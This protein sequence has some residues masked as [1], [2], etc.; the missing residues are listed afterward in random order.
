MEGRLAADNSARNPQ[1]TATT[2]NAL[3]IGVFLV[4]LV[5]VSGTSVKDFAVGEINKL[6][7]ADYLVVSEG[8]TIDPRLVKDLKGIDGVDRVVPFRTEVVSQDRTRASVSTGD[9]AQLRDIADIDVEQG[10]IDA[11]GPG[12]IAVIDT[13]TSRT[14]RLGAT[15]EV[16]TNDGR[17]A[18]L[19]VVALLK[20][21]IDANVVGSIV[22]RTTF[23]RLLGDVAPTVAFLDLADGAQTS[24]RHAIERRV[25]LRPD[26]TLQEGNAAGRLIG[27]IFD[28]MINAVVG[29]LLM[30]VVIA[31][32]GII[33][34]LS[35]SI[36]ERRRELGLL[37]VIGMTDD[38]VRR[39]VSLES[40]LI[41]G[42]GTVTGMLAGLWISI[43]LIL[44]INRLTDASIAVS[45][46]YLE[47]LGVLLA[48]VVLGVLAALIPARRSTRLEVLDA[49]GTV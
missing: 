3:L 29:L 5:T 33:N 23:D 42:L 41:A 16:T 12:S 28:F 21:S 7:S 48:G 2:A 6:S 25:E 47:L 24:T 37:R 36:L 49:I 17:S 4:T 30:S 38:R 15:V 9:L 22:D 39:M 46:P 45:V 40:L 44:A 35:L 10:D 20:P 34:T 27:S 32:I 31:L 26:I 14:P 1:R 19:K 18:D 43:S 13:R 11:L 8:G